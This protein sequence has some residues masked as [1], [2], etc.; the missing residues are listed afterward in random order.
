MVGWRILV[1]AVLVLTAL[2]F[3][4][5]VRAVLL[6]FILA[7]IVA[8]VLEP[9]VR[10]LR[11]R[12]YSRFWAVLM[13][14][15]VFF[16]LL[17][18]VGILAAP[19]VVREVTTVTKKFEDF[20]ASLTQVNENNNFFVRWN[21]A[22]QAQQSSSKDQIDILLGQA[23]PILK[24]L[25]LPTTRRAITDQYIEPRRAQIAQGVKNAF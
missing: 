22:L 11:L 10:R 8:A 25:G 12:G 4:Y 17:T 23:S 18:G 5:L 9:S 15:F 2:I 20:T 3:L 13:V 19:T 14:F 16:G 24:R 21:P 6:P 1:W 7:F